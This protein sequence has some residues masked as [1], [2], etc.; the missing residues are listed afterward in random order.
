MNDALPYSP[1]PSTVSTWEAHT[2]RASSFQDDSLGDDTC[3]KLGRMLM[4]NEVWSQSISASNQQSL[5]W[6]L[7]NAFSFR[8]FH[9]TQVLY[10]L[11]ACVLHM[12][13]EIK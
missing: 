13:R 7:K 2:T 1:N 5:L 12:R 8:S 4:K 3:G 10:H 11:L 9:G 6:P